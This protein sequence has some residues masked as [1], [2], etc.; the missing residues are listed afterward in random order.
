MYKRQGSEGPYGVYHSVFDNYDW[1]V[2]NADPHFVYLEQMARVLG[3]EGL[4]MADADVLPYD[5][6]TY[7]NSIGAYVATVKRKAQDAGLGGIDF[8]PLD[9]A[10]GRFQSAAQRV[11]ARQLAPMGDPTKL[12]KLNKMCIRDRENPTAARNVAQAV[13]DSIERLAAFPGLGPVSYTH[14]D[15]YKRQGCGGVD[16]KVG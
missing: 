8:G 3:L 12:D 9:G 14:L 11:H 6:V 4:R 5:Y 2:Q 13:I 15:V 7:A 10:V 16:G 1:F